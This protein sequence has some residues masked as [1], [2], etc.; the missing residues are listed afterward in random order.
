M[1]RR[2]ANFKLP[3]IV[4][5]KPRTGARRT[6]RE[7][8]EDE[9]QDKYTSAYSLLQTSYKISEEDYRKYGVEHGLLPPYL[10]NPDSFKV[11]SRNLYTSFDN[12][13]IYNV[14]SVVKL[15]T[16]DL[17]NELPEGLCGISSQFLF[18]PFIILN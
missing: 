3:N 11:D 8:K 13:N 12:C 5:P 15:D 1:S 6:S 16:N 2:L 18:I 7:K 17:F 9:S 10:S 14:G 4:T